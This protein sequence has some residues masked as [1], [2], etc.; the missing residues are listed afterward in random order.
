MSLDERGKS[1]CVVHIWLRLSSSE[2]SVEKNGAEMITVVG[3]LVC[4]VVPSKTNPSDENANESTGSQF[5]AL[6]SVANAEGLNE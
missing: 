1:T 2:N 5:T 4:K 6:R 3:A